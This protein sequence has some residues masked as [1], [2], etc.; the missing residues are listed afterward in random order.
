MRLLR[1]RLRCGRGRRLRRGRVRRHPYADH[2][3]GT[4]GTRRRG[5]DRLLRRG[6][7]VA[8]LRTGAQDARPPPRRAGRPSQRRDHRRGEPRLALAGRGS[9]LRA[10]WR[11]AGEC[12]SPVLRR[13][14]PARARP[15]PRCGLGDQGL[16]C[17]DRGRTGTLGRPD[18]RSPRA[19]DH[20]VVGDPGP[21]RCDGRASR[22]GLSALDRGRHADGGR[23]HRRPAR[24]AGFRRGRRDDGARRGHPGL[25]RTRALR[26]RELRRVARARVSSQHG[27]LD[28]SPLCGSR[29]GR[30]RDARRRDRARSG[31]AGRR[32]AGC[33]PRALR[34]RRLDRRL[35]RRK[36]GQHRDAHAVRGAPRG[37]HARVCGSPGAFVRETSPRRAWTA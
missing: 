29:T 5:R 32:R 21:G 37:R 17:R 14:R 11:D 10:A 3:L 34:Q 15:A 12:G 23:H 30:P 31:S 27:L 36:R 26:G 33:G 22:V 25:P 20:L 13:S 24:R 8:P 2:H 7:A 18:V 9:G 1:L 4:G 28:R 16:P 19:D 6:H 35:A